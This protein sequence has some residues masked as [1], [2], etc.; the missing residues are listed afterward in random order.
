MNAKW[1]TLCTLFCTH[2]S[3]VELMFVVVVVANEIFLLSFINGSLRH[4]KPA[5]ALLPFHI[6]F[7]VRQQKRG[8]KKQITASSSNSVHHQIVSLRFVLSKFKLVLKFRCVICLQ[9]RLHH[10]SDERH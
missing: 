1:K 10:G 6:I 5:N 3:F 4:G 9:A 2:Q 7:W 8:N